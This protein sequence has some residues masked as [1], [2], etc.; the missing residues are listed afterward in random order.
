[1]FRGIEFRCCCV[2]IICGVEVPCLFSDWWKLNAG[3][4]AERDKTR[5]NSYCF[6]D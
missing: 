3:V 2:R 6:F 4:G 5:V 1:V